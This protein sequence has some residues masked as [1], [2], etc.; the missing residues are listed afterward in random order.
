[1]YFCQCNMRRACQN[2]TAPH[3][4]SSMML[5]FH[6]KPTNQLP[7]SFLTT[8]TFTHSRLS[9]DAAVW[10]SPGLGVLAAEPPP[11]W[12]KQTQRHLP[13]HFSTLTHLSYPRWGGW[14]FTALE[15]EVTGAR[16]FLTA[17]MIRRISVAFWLLMVMEAKGVRSR[18]T[19]CECVWLLRGY[20]SLLLPFLPLLRSSFA[21]FRFI[22]WSLTKIGLRNNC[23]TQKMR[24]FGFLKVYQLL[25]P[26]SPSHCLHSAL[27]CRVVFA[28]LVQR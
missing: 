2:K 5:L 14:G 23:T 16:F 12:M 25:N 3:L 10:F 27:F 18:C 22:F 8:L 13:R 9:V 15:S 17:V 21:P 6:W 24:S 28:L 1:M 4:R 20:I 26:R 7:E 11:S 19:Y